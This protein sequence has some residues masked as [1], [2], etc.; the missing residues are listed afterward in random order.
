MLNATQNLVTVSYKYFLTAMNIIIKI[1]NKRGHH[2]NLGTRMH[3][4]LVFTTLDTNEGRVMGL[5]LFFLHPLLNMSK[6]ISAE[7]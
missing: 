1:E 6:T 5:F 4:D 3:I 2:L 7:T